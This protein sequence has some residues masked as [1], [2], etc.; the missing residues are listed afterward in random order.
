MPGLFAYSI[1]LSL[2]LGHA[3]VY[4]PKLSSVSSFSVPSIEEKASLND[5]WS[6]WCLEYGGQ[7]V[8]RPTG[9]AIRRCN[10]DCRTCRHCRYDCILDCVFVFTEIWLC[11]EKDSAS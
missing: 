1:R 3:S 2:V 6:N 5:V 8:S 9:R 4:S 10:G 11:A 7:R